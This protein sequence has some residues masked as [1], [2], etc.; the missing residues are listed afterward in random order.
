VGRVEVAAVGR[1]LFG[2]LAVGAL[3]ILPKEQV[4]G[5]HLFV[6]F[7][8]AKATAGMSC[9]PNN[10]RFKRKKHDTMNV[11]QRMNGETVPTL[12]SRPSFGKDVSPPSNWSLRSTM[13]VN[14]R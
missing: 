1:V 9:I 11:C 13:V 8:T 3:E 7:R 4:A 5:G 6:S 10:M 2:E 12:R 14:A